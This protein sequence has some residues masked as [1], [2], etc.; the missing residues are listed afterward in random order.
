[1]VC[2]EEFKIVLSVAEETSI[3]C[4]L[5]NEWRYELTLTPTEKEAA[6]TTDGKA[7]IDGK[8]IYVACQVTLPK[9]YTFN[10]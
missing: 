6:M 2:T 4:P 10:Q 3:N 1:M 9:N 7:L 8:E 5:P